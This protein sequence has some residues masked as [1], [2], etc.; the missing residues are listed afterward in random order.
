M[1]PRHVIIVIIIITTLFKRAA[2]GEQC[3]PHG[4]CQ[5]APPHCIDP[6]Q[7]PRFYTLS[8]LQLHLFSLSPSVFAML[9]YYSE[10]RKKEKRIRGR[11]HA[12]T[13]AYCH[14]TRFPLLLLVPC[15]TDTFVIDIAHG[16]RKGCY[17]SP[18][19]PPPFPKIIRNELKAEC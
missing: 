18:L 11:Y 14:S 17:F 12:D 16:T 9:F 3:E 13:T 19:K 5:R 2:R 15:L 6:E 4:L 8:L 1:A 7:I 10:E